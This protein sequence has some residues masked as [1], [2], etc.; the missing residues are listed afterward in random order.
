M[1]NHEV[2]PEPPSVRMKRISTVDALRGIAS[3]AVC[4]G[5]LYGANPF[6]PQGTSEKWIGS[7]GALGVDVFFVISGFIIPYALH[8][9]GYQ[10][11][12]YGTFILKRVL[13]LDPPYLANILFIIPLGY[14]CAMAPG[15]QGPP[16][17]VSTTQVLLHLAYLNVFFGE[18]WLNPVF[19]TLAI[20]FQYYL[21]VGLAYP[22][23]SHRSLTM[24]LVLFMCLGSLSFIVPKESFILHWLFLFMLGML[25]F[26]QN[27]G[28]IAGMRFWVVLI[29]LACGACY[30][31]GPLVAAVGLAAACAIV[32]VKT[33]NKVLSFLGTISYSLYLFHMPIGCKLVSL[34]SRLAHSVSAKVVVFGIGL[35]LCVAAAYLLYRLVEKPAQA[36]SSRIKYRKQGTIDHQPGL[37]KD[38]VV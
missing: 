1:K 10:L 17:K 18:S 30:A 12:Q 6:L 35:A 21:L 33:S 29:L 8:K 20:E 19:W 4:S 11:K 15:F 26:Q 23:I 3:F 9:S 24:R 13:R 2:I 7:L 22:F 31:L 16:F 5:H 28:L 34:G 36:W 37:Q 38:C 25:A 14:L 32:F 27:V